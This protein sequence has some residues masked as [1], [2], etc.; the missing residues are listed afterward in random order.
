M[1]DTISVTN[2]TLFMAMGLHQTAHFQNSIHMMNKSTLALNIVHK[3]PKILIC[4]LEDVSTPLT[5]ADEQQ[6]L[7]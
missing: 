1:L 2:L 6:H 3:N 7:V 5:S 4:G